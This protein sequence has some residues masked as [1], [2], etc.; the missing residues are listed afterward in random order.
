MKATCSSETSVDFQRLH[1]VI[2]QKT[3]LFK[4][5][6]ISKKKALLSVREKL[7]RMSV[8]YS[9]VDLSSTH[10]N[11]RAFF[12]GGVGVRNDKLWILKSLPDA[13]CQ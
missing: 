2:F 4:L 13:G 1:S 3:E 5:F 12:W 7:C 9:V 10:T 8:K 11:K 6:I